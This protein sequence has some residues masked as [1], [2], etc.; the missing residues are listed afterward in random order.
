MPSRLMSIHSDKFVVGLRLHGPGMGR[1]GVEAAGTDN[2]RANILSPTV[3]VDFA[4][5]GLI[6]YDVRRMN[7]SL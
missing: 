3:G 4:E 2:N 1:S 7:N 6:T 5:D